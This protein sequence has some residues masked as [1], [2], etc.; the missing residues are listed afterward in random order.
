MR[1]DAGAI[2]AITEALREGSVASRLLVIETLGTGDAPQPYLN[3]VLND[4]DETVRSG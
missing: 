1:D 2:S 4:A 3:D